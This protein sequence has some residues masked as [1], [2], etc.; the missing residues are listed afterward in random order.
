MLFGALWL[1]LGIAQALKLAHARLGADAMFF[2][3]P[4]PSEPA[5]FLLSTP[6]LQPGLSTET[7]SKLRTQKGIDKVTGQ[8]FI[9]SAP[10]PCC[11]LSDTMLVGFDPL[12]DMT[13]MP[14]LAE[15][16]SHPLQDG[17]VVAGSNILSEPGGRIT[18]FG[19]LFTIAGKLKPTGSRSTDSAIYI[20]MA[21]A[22]RMLSEAP[23][24]SGQQLDIPP[25]ALSVAL[26]KFTTDADHERTAL[27]LEHAFNGHSAVLASDALRG[28]RMGLRAP[29]LA[30]LFVVII[31]WASTVVL[32]G[33]IFSLN[34]S[35]KAR[36]TEILRAI[37]ANRSHLRWMFLYEALA[38]ASAGSLFGAIVSWACMWI[39]AGYFISSSQFAFLHPGTP[40]SLAIALASILLMTVSICATALLMARPGS[41][42]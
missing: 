34:L 8:L 11:S 40:A 20:P 6:A 30:A 37:G 10:L 15:P 2:K 12:D 9:L 3:G 33:A 29:A 25:D 38:I 26:I 41:W 28:A 27:M 7:L 24:R 22:R 13:V 16:L 19:S 39:F 21:G 4:P 1:A 17:E 31:I 5:S 42:R 36:E 18:F 23:A 35:L 32:S 14:W